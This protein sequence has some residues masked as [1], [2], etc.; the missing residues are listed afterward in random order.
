M[1]S[2]VVLPRTSGTGTGWAPLLRK[3]LTCAFIGS[4]V[5][6][7]GS[8]FAR[9]PSGALLPASPACTGVSPASRIRST[10]VS[11]ASPGCTCGTRGLPLDTSTATVEPLVTLDPAG[12]SLPTTP[13]TGTVSEA[14]GLVSASN[15][16]AARAWVASSVVSP[17]TGG[18]AA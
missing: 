15:P 13:P 5:P 4:T 11:I 7:A 17:A 16:A 14:L 8:T 18:T 3:I 6:G 12:G 2:S 10:T 9:V 1:A